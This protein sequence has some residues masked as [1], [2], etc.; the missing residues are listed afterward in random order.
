MACGVPCVVTEVGESPTLVG[1][2][3]LVVG[4]RNPEAL[5]QAWQCLLEKGPEA[6]RRLG[7]AARQRIVER[8]ALDK[9]AAQ[10]E[11]LYASVTRIKRC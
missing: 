6:R 5:A 2:T 3:G 9:I 10:Y 11:A 7:M 4:A 1:E 8:Y